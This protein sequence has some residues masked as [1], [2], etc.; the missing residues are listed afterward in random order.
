MDVTDSVVILFGFSG[1]IKLKFEEIQ[2]AAE[3]KQ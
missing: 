3:L 1:K 2:M